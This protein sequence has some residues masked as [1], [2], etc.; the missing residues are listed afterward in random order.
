MNHIFLTLPQ[1]KEISNTKVH[2]Q[3]AREPDTNILKLVVTSG[4]N[5][6][7][8]KVALDQ[9]SLP[10]KINLHKQSS[11]IMHVELMQLAINH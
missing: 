7:K 1:I 3:F 8:G 2:L 6:S 11:D 10:D 5:A 9:V 4:K